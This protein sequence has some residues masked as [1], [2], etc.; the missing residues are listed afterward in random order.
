MTKE[1][2]LQLALR[3]GFDVSPFTGGSRQG[4]MS[5]FDSGDVDMYREL[6]NFAYL[7][8]EYE[9]E[10]CAKI[11]QSN[12]DACGLYSISRRVLESNARA[13]RARSKK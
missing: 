3:A 13:I 1:E 7:V 2:L 5:V 10:A 8:A 4:K 9:R 12:A 11:V 6:K